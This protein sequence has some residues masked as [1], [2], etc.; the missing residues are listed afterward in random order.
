MEYVELT[1]EQIYNDV[2]AILN[3][4]IEVSNEFRETIGYRVLSDILVVFEL[5]NVFNEKFDTAFVSEVEVDVE[6]QSLSYIVR[7]E[8]KDN[9]FIEIK[10]EKNKASLLSVTPGFLNKF[11]LK[12]MIVAVFN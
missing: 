5:G 3:F 12:Q 10:V 1:R 2:S 7:I 11:K 6:T 8:T 9:K 4:N